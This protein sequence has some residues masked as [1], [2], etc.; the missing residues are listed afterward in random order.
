MHMD[1]RI[2]CK[3]L[4]LV[5]TALYNTAY[6]II[7]AS[8]NKLAIIRGKEVGGERITETTSFP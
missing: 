6:I 5:S 3:T 1:N 2:A 4:S 7:A 8:E